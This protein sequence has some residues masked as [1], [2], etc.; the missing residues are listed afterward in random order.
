MT[1]RR[2]LRR[3][4]AALMAMMLVLAG[5]GDDDGD[6]SAV[7]PETTTT[8]TT[9][10]STDD[11]GDESDGEDEDEAEEPAGP[12]LSEDPA[13]LD[14]AFACLDEGSGDAGAVLLV[15]GTGLTSEGSY[16]ATLAPALAADGFAVCTVD[17]VDTAT[18]DIQRSAEYV[19]AALRSMAADGHEEIALVGFSQGAVASRWAITWWDDV[20]ALV[21]DLVSISGPHGGAAGAAPLCAAGCAAALH[22]MT[23]GSAFLTALDEAWAALDD[24]P[25]LTLIGSDAD[26]VVSVA[27]AAVG[28]Q[29]PIRVQEICP[30]R[31]TDHVA[32][33][34]EPVVHALLLDALT[35]DGPADPGRIDATV[36]DGESL[37]ADGWDPLEV[38][39][40][41]F[42]VILG[43]TPVT[44][45][46][47]LA[48][49]AS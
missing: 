20:R 10:A 8:E 13:D 25:P 22:Q 23:P 40:A 36:C 2:V 24:T 41:S 4:A 49:Y 27:E 26:T 18:G 32:L 33:L 37:A 43:A 3:L 17:L 31:A 34:A 47:P 21:T 38:T 28:D 9:E 12:E 44:E 45:E 35:N 6:D 15:P 5:C 46:P 42:G 30:D 11:G 19:V 1:D 29:A 7:D 16:A 14:A 48:A 39:N